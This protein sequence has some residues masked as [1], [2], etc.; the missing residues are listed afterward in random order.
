VKLVVTGAAGGLGRAFL[1]QLPE[2]HQV[3][4]FDR[5]GLDVGDHDVVM[6]SI[7]PLG[8]DAILNF[9]AFTNVDANET[10]PVRAARDNALGP[11]NVALAARACGAALVHI[12]TDYVFDGAKG[13]PYDELD[14][15]SPISVYGRA[16]AAGDDNVRSLLA[17][18]LIVRVGHVYGGGSDYLTRA[19]KI[20]ATGEQVGGIKDRTGTPTY[21]HDIAARLMPLLVTHR[22]GTYHLASPTS[23]SWFEVL[24]SVRSI[25]GFSGQVQPQQASQL[26]LKAPRP[27]N[28]ALTSLYLE[29][30]GTAPMPPL[31]DALTRFLERLR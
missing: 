14:A 10:D 29:H 8:P 7:P 17:E 27:V 21:V 18:H 4:A 2:H 12:S 25:G 30:L 19:A 28:S 31:E 22:W 20:L 23:C 24:T 11:A 5:A 1:Q 16:K 3:H 26:S 13:S 15:P 6:R 9:A